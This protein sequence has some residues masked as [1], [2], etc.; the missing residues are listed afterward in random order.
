[1]HMFS[2]DLLAD[3]LLTWSSCMQGYNAT[4]RGGF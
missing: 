2:L 4:V 1:M 3:V